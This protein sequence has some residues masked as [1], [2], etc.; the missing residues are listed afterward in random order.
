MPMPNDHD[1]F[2]G[3]H[4]DLLQ[5]GAVMDRRKLLRLAAGFGVRSSPR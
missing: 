2:G 5:T 4:R 1:D 3:L